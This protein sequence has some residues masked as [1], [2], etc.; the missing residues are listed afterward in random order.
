MFQSSIKNMFFAY[1]PRIAGFAP[2]QGFP[3]P[4]PLPEGE[5]IRWQGPYRPR[6][7]AQG[8]AQAAPLAVG[9]NFRNPKNH[10]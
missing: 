3:H 4:S 5:G 1:V 8:Y 6:I 2:F 10:S 7:R 9:R